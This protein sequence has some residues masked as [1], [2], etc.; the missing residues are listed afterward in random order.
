MKTQFF[1]ERVNFGT[2]IN[3]HMLFDPM[4]GNKRSVAQPV[5]LESIEDDAQTFWEPM[6]S[7]S[8]VDAQC[9]MDELWSIG[10]RPTQEKQSEVQEQHLADMRAIAFAK[11]WGPNHDPR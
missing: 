2:K 1:A 4:T 7:L 5:V 8:T 10:L 11:F 9:L 3:L 6:M